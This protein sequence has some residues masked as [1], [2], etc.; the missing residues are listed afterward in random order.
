[1][2]TSFIIEN[3]VKIYPKSAKPANDN[4]S[5][6]VQQGEVFGLLGPNGAGKSTLVRQL[7]GMV[8]PT[9][10][11]IR[12]FDV[13]MIKNPREASHF[14]SL[15]PQNIW[16][17]AQSMP[18]ELLEVTARL[19][20]VHPAQAKKDAEA[21]IGEFGLTPHVGKKIQILSGG[22]RRLVAIAV[23]IIG[24]RPVVILDEPTNDLDPEI[25]RAVWKR[26]QQTSQEG[27]TVILVTHN[28]VEAEHTL[29]R[30]GI[31]REG[32]ILAV[33]TPEQLKSHIKQNVRLEVV[34]NPDYTTA[35]TSFILSKWPHAVQ[36]G[37]NRYTITLPQ[38][39][40]QHAIS[41]LLPNLNQMMDFRIVSSNLEDIYFEL[42]GGDRI[43]N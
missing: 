14:V 11:T 29:N 2:Q 10:G 28:V 24:G 42:S 31:M 23:T 12:L 32:K 36:L 7:A 16:L 41:E 22:L 17:P 27:R 18:L 4:V 15:Q 43:A 39:A 25:R 21:L 9:S 33:G 40:V 6:T 34:I 35:I 3:L 1:M 13:D 37:A 19:R 20:G 26:I 8:K 30:V 38:Q 5:L